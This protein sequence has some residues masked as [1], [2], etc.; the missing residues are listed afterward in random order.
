MAADIEEIHELVPVM[1]L[2]AALS[3]ATGG[4]MHAVGLIAS[5]RDGQP[6]LWQVWTVF[7]FAIPA[8]FA[9][10]ALI[11]GNRRPGY[12]IALI[13]PPIGGLLI[14]LGLFFPETQLL[15]L[16]PGTYQHEITLIGFITL[17]CEP[18]AT[19]LAAILVRLRVWRTR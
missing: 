18:A 17:V 9:S 4:I 12:M 16:I 8:Y 14:A 5:I 1:R 3:I 7:L 15:R 10:A 2:A 11:L 13:C 6:A 19:V